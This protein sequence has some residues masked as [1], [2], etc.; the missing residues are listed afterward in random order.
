[1]ST[2]DYNEINL[3]GHVWIVL[4]PISIISLVKSWYNLDIFKYYKKNSD[5]IS[6]LWMFV[7]LLYGGQL[8]C[9]SA[10]QDI[11]QDEGYKFQVLLILIILSY[12]VSIAHT[13]VPNLNAIIV[14]S[15]VVSLGVFLALSLWWAPLHGKSA[16]NNLSILCMTS[17]QVVF[18]LAIALASSTTL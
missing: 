14:A 18:I 16:G 10:S 15:N 8:L 7:Y 6:V 2:F 9:I 4:L 13:F 3:M 11:A 1:M 17:L 5:T 12:A